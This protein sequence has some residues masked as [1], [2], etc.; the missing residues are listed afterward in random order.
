VSSAGIVTGAIAGVGN[1]VA[2]C[3]PGTCNINQTYSVFSNAVA[4][5]V[6]GTPSNTVYA[7]STGGTS[8]VPIDTTANTA[9]TAFTLANAPNSVVADAAGSKVYFGTS[10]GVVQYTTSGGATSTNSTLTG[11]VISVSPNGQKI[12]VSDT[13]NNKVFVADVTSTTG[14]IETFGLAGVS[15]AS[16]TPDNLKAF[17]VSGSNLYVYSTLF[18]LKTIALAGPAND[19]SVLGSGQ[20]AYLAGGAPNA[21]NV[22]ETCDQAQVDSVATTATP[23]NIASLYNG[24][25]VLAVDAPTIDAI[26]LAATPAGACPV[27]VNETLTPHDLGQGAF[28]AKQFLVS[29]DN[30]HAFVMTASNVIIYNVGDG[31]STAVTLANSATPTMAAVTTDGAS[32]Y[33][34]GSDSAVHLID[35]ASA[36]DKQQISVGFVPDLIALR[37]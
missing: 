25:Q 23:T 11:R 28:M 19:V 33:V 24:A 2:A 31:S 4:A 32:L 5:T 20:L 7:A 35:V 15:A 22:R 14:S 6:S 12:V 16:W 3:A 37:Q 9:G 10:G 1:I 18:S 34:G 26:V 30:A 8:V 29:P 36:T 17:L 27:T 13:T 21:V